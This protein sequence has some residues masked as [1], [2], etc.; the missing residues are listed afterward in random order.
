MC[1]AGVRGGGATLRKFVVNTAEYCA[2]A[3]VNRG[4]TN[5]K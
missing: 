1:C 4:A 3:A 2:K 5:F